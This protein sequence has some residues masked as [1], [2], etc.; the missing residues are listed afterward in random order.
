MRSFRFKS[1]VVTLTSVVKKCYRK[2]KK[3]ME[4][5][6]L[7]LPNREIFDRILNARNIKKW[8]KVQRS[9]T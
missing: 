4:T 9:R 2:A 8:M 6:W 3:V 7:N 5:E 1:L